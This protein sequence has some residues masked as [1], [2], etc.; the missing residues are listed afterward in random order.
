M[1]DSENE[2]V[3]VGS[4]ELPVGA[5]DG[6]PVF[7]LLWAQVDSERL[8]EIAAPEKA[9]LRGADF[10]RAKDSTEGWSYQRL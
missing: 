8:D 9:I 3:D 1:D 5:V 4:S 7:L 10:Y 6:K 2:D